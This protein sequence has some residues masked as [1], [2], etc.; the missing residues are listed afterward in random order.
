MRCSS[1]K[2]KK[3]NSL[4]NFHFIRKLWGKNSS[5][6]STV[7][8]QKLCLP[9]TECSGHRVKHS[10]QV[11][12]FILAATDFIKLCSRWTSGN[13]PSGWNLM[14]DLLNALWEGQERVE[15]LTKQW[16]GKWCR[17][18]AFVWE[19]KAGDAGP[20]LERETVRVRGRGN[21][22]ESPQG[23]LGKCSWMTAFWNVHKWR[24]LIGQ[25]LRLV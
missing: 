15:T 1:E 5:D 4:P 19:D 6:T 2:R 10:P 3:R 8:H 7:C 18:G 23:L 25:R 14:S 21:V 11:F 13:G 20:G 16:P 9:D 22:V 17:Q 12:S 24:D